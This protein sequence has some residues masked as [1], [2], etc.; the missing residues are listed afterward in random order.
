MAAAH[1]AVLAGPIASL[2]FFRG[3]ALPQFADE[4]ALI[5][6]WV[7]F[8]IYGPALFFSGQLV[9]ARKAGLFVFGRLAEH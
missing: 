3:A 7:I 4:L 1:G 9:T 8:L 6:A 2:I 5:V